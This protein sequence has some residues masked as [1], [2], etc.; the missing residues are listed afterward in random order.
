MEC[1]IAEGGKDRMRIALTQMD[2]VWEDKETNYGRARIL[3]EKAAGAGAD[4]IIFPEMSFTGFSMNVES[5]GEQAG[6]RGAACAASGEGFPTVGRM[7]K[8][9][10]EYGIVIVFGY[11]ESG[12]WRKDA[13]SAGAVENGEDADECFDRKA[14]NVVAAVSREGLLYREYKIHPF[15]Y[16]EEGKYYEGGSRVSGFQVGEMSFGGCV[17][18]DLR[19]PEVFQVSSEKNEA[20]IV[21][22]NWPK[23]RIDHWEVLLRARAIENQC[24]ILGVNRTGEGGGLMYPLSSMAFSPKGERLTAGGFAG[25]EL[26]LVEVDRD[27]VSSYRKEFPVKADR[28]NELY[29][30]WYGGL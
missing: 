13:D 30:N 15:S 7:E 24:Y 27:E 19:F 9:A 18:Y 23:E 28:R 1:E 3:V 10:G 4:M 11:V 20:I 26:L 21:I 8:L 6:G 16:G 5:V 22:A 2:V 12:C 14:A 25:E 17:C 29:K